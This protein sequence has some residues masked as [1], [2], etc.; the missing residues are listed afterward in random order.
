MH[1]IGMNTDHT[2][3]QIGKQFDVTHERIRQFEDKALRKLRHPSHAA[4]LHSFLEQ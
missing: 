1:R 2:L 3:E 4:H